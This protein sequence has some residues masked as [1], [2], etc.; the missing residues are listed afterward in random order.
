MHRHLNMTDD[1]SRLYFPASIPREYWQMGPIRGLITWYQ[2]VG[3][4]AIDNLV[5]AF[6][7]AVLFFIA[8]RRRGPDGTVDETM[9]LLL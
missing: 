7:Q 3:W 6:V 9:P 2:L 5:F 8:W 1:G 4:A